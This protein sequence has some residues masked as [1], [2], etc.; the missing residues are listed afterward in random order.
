MSSATVLISTENVTILC[1]PWLYDGAFYGSWCHYPHVNTDSIDFADIDY[2]YVSHIHPDHFDSE[3]FLRKI[4]HHIPVLIHRFQFPY[5]RNNIERL[6]YNVIELQHGEPFD[7][8]NGVFIEIYGADDCNPETCGK[9]FG[10]LALGAGRGSVQLDSLAVIRDGKHILVNVNDCPFE[11]ADK[12]LGRIAA[13]H[14]SIDLA[15]VGFSSASLYPHCMKNYDAEEME[16]AKQ[17]ARLRGLNSC[18]G[19]LKVLKPRYYMP[20][21]GTY[22]LGGSLAHKTENLPITEFLEIDKFLQQ[23]PLFDAQRTKP[24]FLNHGSSFDL[25]RGTCSAPFKPPSAA[26]RVRYAKE[27][28]VNRTF[29]YETDPMP[30]YEDFADI[31]GNCFAR[32]DRK[33]REMGLVDSHTV[34]FALPEHKAIRLPLDGAPCVIEDTETPNGES[35]SWFDV[36][37]R[38]LMRV[39]RGPARANW[40]NVEIGA[41]L[42]FERKPDVYYPKMHIALNYFHE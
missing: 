9:L 37:P 39:F 30:S 6:G 18:L 42:M 15:L 10:C 31:L 36:D 4:P 11:I 23:D 25:D 22:V 1:D 34:F 2:V 41:H 26:D 40:N 38:L 29:P 16:R 28:L 5:L 27:V 20:F 7:L 24:V 19:T 33:R 13:D 8:G 21:A 3:T 32:F 12:A 14:G 17:R 35:Y